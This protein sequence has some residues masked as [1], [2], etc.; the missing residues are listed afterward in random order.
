MKEEEIVNTSLYLVYMCF[1]GQAY[2]YVTDRSV[3][4]IAFSCQLRMCG[5]EK[6]SWSYTPPF[7]N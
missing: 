5:G 4:P 7:L 6:R 3:N 2:L 1:V